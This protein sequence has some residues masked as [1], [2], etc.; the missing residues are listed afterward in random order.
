MKYITTI[1]IVMIILVGAGF[2]GW[3][4]FFPQYRA[5]PNDTAQVERGLVV[6]QQY[7]ATCH[8][9]NLEGQPEWRSRKPDG[10]LPAP[11][12]DETGHTWHHSDEH[13]IGITKYGLGKFVPGEYESDM[14]AFEGTLPDEDIWAVIAY[15]KSVWPPNILERQSKTNQ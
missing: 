10:R 9:K 14:P 15:I 13:L 8:G 1:S 12:H 7:C 6:Y 2:W 4:S 3:K 11:P 5:D